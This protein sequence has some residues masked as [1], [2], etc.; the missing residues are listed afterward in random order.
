MHSDVE[1]EGL[2][3]NCKYCDS[4]GRGSDQRAVSNRAYNNVFQGTGIIFSV[5][6]EVH[7]TVGQVWQKIV[8]SNIKP[9]YD[10]AWRL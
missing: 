7:W 2:Y 10:Q 9:L 6:A 3:Q 4:Q 1:Q 5:F 8:L